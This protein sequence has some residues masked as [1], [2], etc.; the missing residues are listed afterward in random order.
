MRFRTFVNTFY[1]YQFLHDFILIYAVDKLFFVQS[2]ISLTQIATLLS[3]WAITSFLL[4]I[5]TG[6]LADKWNRKTMLILGG[7]F[8]AICYIIWLV[9]PTFEGFLL[10]FAF[11]SLASTF[12]SGTLQAYTYDFLSVKGKQNLFEKIWGRGRALN[13][14]GLSLGWVFGGMVSEYSYWWVLVLSASAGITTSIIAMFF[15]SIRKQA[16]LNE[17]NPLAFIRQ[18][19]S[20]AFTHRI[21]LNAFLFAA[22]VQSSYGVIDEYWPILFQHYDI[23]NSVL[24]ISVA[25]ASLLGGL[26]GSFAHRFRKQPWIIL[27]WSTLYISA[28]LLTTAFVRSPIILFFLL[29]FEIVVGVTSVLVEGVIQRNVPN[30]QRATMASVNS[31]LREVAIVTGLIFGFIGD[32]VGLEYGYAFFGVFV[33]IYL[34]GQYLI[35]PNKLTTRTA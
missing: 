4:E 17:P 26:A 13:L 7:I 8:Y 12:S 5:P 1:L 3:I 23:S 24:G 6:I 16:D 27:N 18:A 2:G 32:K 10:G 19:L 15:P 14:A 33:L 35:N 28:V 30:N 25:I 21:I 29:T 9:Y 31:M 34:L 22:V 20:Y 11:R